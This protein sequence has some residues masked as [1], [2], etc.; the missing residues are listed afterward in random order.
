MFSSCIGKADGRCRGAARMLVLA[1]SAC[2]G[3]C[4]SGCQREERELRLD[5]PLSAALDQVKLMPN[6]ISGAPPEVY[7]A[8]GKP[9]ENNAYSL[10]QGKRLYTW[11]GCGE[12]HGDG[13]GTA[14]G[15]S[16]MD[17]WWNYGPEMV[18][19]FASIRDGRPQG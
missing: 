13:R 14:K 16:L 4:L 15:P 11:F 8:L 18:S 7:F 6:R 5:P 1:C 19:V 10:S 9:Y 12:C 2:V 3:L 17:G